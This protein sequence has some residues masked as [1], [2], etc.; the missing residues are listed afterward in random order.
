MALAWAVDDPIETIDR[1]GSN[2]FS[3]VGCNVNG[4]GPDLCGIILSGDGNIFGRR[5][6][7]GSRRS[8]ISRGIIR[9]R[10]SSDHCADCGT[11]W[12]GHGYGTTWAVDDPIETIDRE[13]SNFF[14]IVGS[15]VNG[16]GPDFVEL[17]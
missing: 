7:K 12:Y 8:R 1:E 9:D 16:Y 13:G 6:V 3:I 4:Y 10:E 14:S 11:V 15:N 2:F 5:K 17:S